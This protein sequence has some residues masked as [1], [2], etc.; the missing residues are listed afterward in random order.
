[1]LK[2]TPIDLS[3][4]LFCRERRAEIQK[5]YLVKFKK[6]VI[7]FSLNIPGP[8]KTS[9]AIAQ[10]FYEGKQE[11]LSFLQENN[12]SILSMTEFHE[13]SGDELI[14]CTDLDAA[15]I[16]DYTSSIE[17]NHS[18]GRLFDIDVIDITGNKLGRN[19]PRKCLMCEKD[20]WECSASRAHSAEELQRKVEELL[21][22]Y[23]EKK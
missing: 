22:E 12:S 3:D 6:P 7:S 21:E 5:K 18:L 13:P 14:L 19:R 16:K 1:M 17:E 15:S 20:V 9:H 23:F 8:I 11:I 10:L 2:G 4:M